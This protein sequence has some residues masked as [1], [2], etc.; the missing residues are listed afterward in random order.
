MCVHARTRVCFRRSQSMNFGSHPLATTPTAKGRLHT[1]RGHVRAA[2]PLFLRRFLSLV[3]FLS[4]DHVCSPLR[5]L[6]SFL[7]PGDGDGSAAET[8]EKMSPEEK[9]RTCNYSLSLSAGKHDYLRR[10]NSFSLPFSLPSERER[11]KR[12]V[13]EERM[14]LFCAPFT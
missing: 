14:G 13:F 10:V 9:N 8:W 1:Y 7:L 11:K 4:L 6:L 5:G 12:G 3:L 2:Y